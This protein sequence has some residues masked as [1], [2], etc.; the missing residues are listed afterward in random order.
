MLEGAIFKGYL[1]LKNGE[2][3]VSVLETSSDLWVSF[4]KKYCKIFRREIGH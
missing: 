3:S 1:F 2:L 4:S